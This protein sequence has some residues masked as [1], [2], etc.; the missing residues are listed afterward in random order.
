MTTTD[1]ASTAGYVLV[2]ADPNALDIAANVRDGVIITDDPGFI[3]SITAHGVLQAVSAVR[4]ADGTLAVVD[5]QRRTLAA[6]EAGL[7]AIPVL[8]REETPE[9]KTATIERITAQVV[10]NDHREDLT[11][12]Q[13]MGAVSQLLDLGLSVTA[14]AK[15]LDLRRDYT[16]QAGRAGRSENARRRVDDRQLSLEGAALL[17]DL[18]AVAES[19]PWVADAIEKILG[20]GH[21]IVYPLQNLRRRIDER[22]AAALAAADHTARG[23]A[24]L[25]DEPATHTGQWLSLAD[26]R[27]AGGDAAA[28]DVPEQAPHLWHVH[29]YQ[30]GLVWVDKKSRAEVDDD[31]IDYDTEDD[32]D[33]VP[34]E[35]MVH[36]DSVEQIRQWH[37]EF[38]LHRD[39]LADTGLELAPTA[40]A[41][42]HDSENGDD[43]LT[44]A[45]RAAARAEAERVENERAERRKVK[46]LNRAGATATDLRRSFITGLLAGKSAP[47]SATKW[48]IGILADQGDVFTESKC[49]ERYAEI[50]NTPLTNAADKAENVSAG[51]AEVLL[52]ARVLTAFEARLTGPQDAKDYWRFSAKHYRGMVGIDSYLTFLADAGHTPTPV[53]QAAIGNMSIDDAHAA[54]T[55]D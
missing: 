34:E 9:E 29:V 23:F 44:A 4:R 21:G 54:V 48:M 8:V 36:F 10:S 14:V 17:A 16:E 35:G 43:G 2:D 27:T 31:D 5:G 19:E 7:A 30:A 3:D 41:L 33:A 24:L 55:D 12:G 26:L 53:E 37:F 47:K 25:H 49:A 6:R 39:H 52:L 15:K 1:T 40:A 42:T 51:R 38:F 45:Q 28:A 18:E 46:A 13:R 32:Q 22:A 50:M 11:H 20:G